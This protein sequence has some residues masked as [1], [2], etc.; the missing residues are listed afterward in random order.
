MPEASKE[1]ISKLKENDYTEVARPE[2]PHG[3][4]LMDS[5]NHEIVSLLILFSPCR[6]NAYCS[7][8][9]SIMLC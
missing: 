4:K 6:S 9:T 7:C 5:R 8:A 3:M 2:T 1:L